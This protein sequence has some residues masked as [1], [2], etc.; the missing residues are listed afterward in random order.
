[1]IL[2]Y[3]GKNCWSFKDWMEIDFRINKNVPGEFGFPDKRVV[4][5]LCFQGGNASGKSCAL[6]VLSFIVDF[7]LNSFSY[8]TDSAILY[9][10]FFYND[11]KS[12]FYITF[13]LTDNINCE[14]TYETTIDRKK[15][16][17]EKLYSIKDGKK[18][19]LLYRS[20]NKL[21]LNEL[22]SCTDAIILKNTASFIST[23]IQYGVSG[24]ESFRHF[25]LS[26]RS[27]VSYRGTQE[28]HLDDTQA[29]YYAKHPEMLSRVVEQ[30]KSYD[31]GV[32]EVEIVDYPDVNGEHR[33]F[34]IFHHLVQGQADRL[35]FFAQS[36]G[37]KVLYNRLKDFFLT[38]DEGGV[39]IFDELDNHMHSSIISL[40][41]DGFLDS[42]SNKRHAQIIFT[43]HNT[44]LLNELKKY[45]TY[46]FKKLQGESICYRIDELPNNNVLR[47]DRSLEASYKAGLLGGLPDV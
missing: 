12:D 39:L 32:R 42:E 13:T 3:G 10:S 44:A 26:V 18:K 35:T 14:Y 40:L 37:T 20:E 9:D 31:T 16:Y 46:L 22:F 34:S 11:E 1:M 41:L 43:S 27:N 8:P 19:I 2:A 47:N 38:I 6:R 24:I 7:C 17:E 25:F 23:F 29:A 30:L 36:T 4:P 28:D 45:R 33:F 5:A 15:I 21:E